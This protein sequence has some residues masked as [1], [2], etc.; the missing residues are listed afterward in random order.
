MNSLRSQSE[1]D[2][3]SPLAETDVRAVVEWICGSSDGADAAGEFFELRGKALVACLLAHML[4][5]PALPP[6]RK[7]LRTLR[8]AV[9]APESKLRR[10]LD[11]IYENCTARWRAIWRERSRKSRTEHSPGLP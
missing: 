6:G 2:T 5:D 7:T 11:G 10:I 1:C 3:A 9:A 4:W 8:A